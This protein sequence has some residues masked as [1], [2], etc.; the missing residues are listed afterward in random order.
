MNCAR[1][2]SPLIRKLSS[3][4]LRVAAKSQWGTFSQQ[5]LGIAPKSAHIWLRTPPDH[6]FLPIV[7]SPGNRSHEGLFEVQNTPW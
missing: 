4:T 7:H 5:V 2:I 3:S 6:Q 1:S